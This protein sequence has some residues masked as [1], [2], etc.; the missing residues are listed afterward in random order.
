MYQVYL[1]NSLVMI[2]FFTL[3]DGRFAIAKGTSNGFMT[4]KFSKGVQIDFDQQS[5]SSILLN[6]H[7]VFND[8]DEICRELRK[9][10]ISLGWPWE[11][12]RS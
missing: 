10:F 6:E 3:N 1:L 11:V 4:G 8:T 9:N 12:S 7:K 2:Y 5:I